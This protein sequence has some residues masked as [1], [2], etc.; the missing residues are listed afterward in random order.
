MRA[1]RYRFPDE[2]RSTT[3]SIASRMIS[4]GSVATTPEQLDAWIS[5][6]PDVRESLVK[7][8]YG[9][10]FT[11]HDLFPLLQVFLGAA[12]QPAPDA[13]ERV[14]ST[15]SGRSWALVVAVALVLLALGVAAVVLA[16]Q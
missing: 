4:D 6:R 8:G 5:Q 14:R 10:A 12:G 1:P 7:G 2:V 16:R 15:K 9:K 13:D 11:S 3:R